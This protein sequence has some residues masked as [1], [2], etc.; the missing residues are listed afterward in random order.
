[1][2]KTKLF[3]APYGT[4]DWKEFDN[5]SVEIDHLDLANPDSCN[6]WWNEIHKDIVTDLSFSCECKMEP[7]D[8]KVLIKMVSPMQN[9]LKAVRDAK[10][11]LENKLHIEMSYDMYRYIQHICHRVFGCNLKRFFK[12]EHIKVKV[13]HE[14]KNGHWVWMK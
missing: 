10:R 7:N 9:L 6:K 3:I 13:R 1:M 8:M 14:T 12:D 11:V 4:E 5:V 2:E